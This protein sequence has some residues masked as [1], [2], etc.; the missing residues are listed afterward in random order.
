MLRLGPDD[1]AFVILNPDRSWV[2][3]GVLFRGS[4][5]AKLYLVK[6]AFTEKNVCLNFSLLRLVTTR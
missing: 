2:E 3:F 1:T 4:I 5:V 6:P